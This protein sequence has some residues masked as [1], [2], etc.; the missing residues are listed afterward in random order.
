MHPKTFK[1]AALFSALLVG[2]AVTI[3]ALP[4]T[5]ESS[6]IIHIRV[7]AQ[8]VEFD[9]YNTGLVKFG[10]LRWRGGL[11]LTSRH[12]RFG[13][14]SGLALDQSGKR[15]I[16]ITDRGWWMSATLKYRN[17]K[18]SGIKNARFT[19]L[20]NDAG[21]PFKGKRWSDSESI[22][23]LGDH[24]ELSRLLVSFERRH[25]ILEYAYG[26]YGLRA[27]GRKIDLPEEIKQLNYNK[28]LEAIAVFGK[29]TEQKGAIIALSERTLDAD[30]NIR[31]WIVNGPY[32]GALA[33]R[34]RNDFELTDAE[35]LPNGDLLILER[36]VSMF[37]G[38]QFQ[39]RR[40]AA[41]TIRPGAILD[42]P[43]LIQ[44]GM[45][46]TID[47]MEGMSLSTAPNGELRLTL[48]SDNNFSLL[49]R[50]LLLQFALP[51]TS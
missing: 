35:T 48:I 21:K 23:S 24:R 6:K 43:L 22:F 27:R 11:L 49:Q 37:T 18:L 2:M 13:G 8:P 31:G 39:I 45:Q 25:R 50:T 15:M 40:I 19:R 30:G 9:P 41:A 20:L 28:G 5:A 29:H 10:K 1:K 7:N 12:K 3:T 42:G 14:F 47:N 44:S 26:Q 32:K 33:V 16:A 51:D 34:R 4:E 17:G 46:H 38:L 36:K